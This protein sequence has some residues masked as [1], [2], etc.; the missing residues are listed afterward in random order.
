MY[1]FSLFGYVIFM[2]SLFTSSK[3]ASLVSNLLYFFTHFCDYAVQSPYQRD[4]EK[5]LASFLPSIAMKRSL[6]NILRFEKGAK[7]LTFDNISE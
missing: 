7:G 1:S 4:V 6:Y 3:V 5:I 2:S